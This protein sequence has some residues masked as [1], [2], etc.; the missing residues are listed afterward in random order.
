LE[1]VS[2]TDRSDGQVVKRSRIH[3]W[4]LF[5]KEE[6]KPDDMVTE[7]LGEVIRICMADLREKQYEVR[8]AVVTMPCPYSSWKRDS[9][10]MLFQ[11]QGLGSCYLFRLDLDQVVDATFKGNLARFVNHSC[12]P[13]CYARTITIETGEKKIVLFA[14][15][16]ISVGEEITYDY[17]FP[18]E[19]DKIECHCGAPEC[20]GSM[21]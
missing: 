7:Y 11:E 8:C 21:N 10:E 4:G 3:G 19:D 12:H 18:I 20:V 9:Y 6:F 15:K 2:V 13:T 16:P 1:G 5:A 17:K 14:Q